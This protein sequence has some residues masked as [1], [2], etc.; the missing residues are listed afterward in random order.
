MW[1]LLLAALA[2]SNWSAIAKRES[3]AD[4]LTQWD[5]ERFSPGCAKTVDLWTVR[6]GRR[7]STTFG[8]SPKHGTLSNSRLPFKQSW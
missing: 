1:A 5:S 2:D 3:S 6:P 4:P 7:L 8:H